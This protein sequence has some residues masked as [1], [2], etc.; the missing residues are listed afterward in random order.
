MSYNIYC[1]VYV[2]VNLSREDSIGVARNKRRRMQ[3]QS[4]ILELKAKYVRILTGSILLSIRSQ[5]IFLWIKL[6]VLDFQQIRRIKYFWEG[7]FV[8][9]FIQ[10][11]IKYKY[12]GYQFV[13][14]SGDDSNV[15]KLFNYSGYRSC[16]LGACNYS[17]LFC[18]WSTSL[19]PFLCFF[20]MW[21]TRIPS[22]LSWCNH[23]EF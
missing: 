19:Y 11:T 6:W 8:E 21:E 22:T 5:I 18:R 23:M 10:G 7:F 9:K 12:A 20:Y 13:C 3:I 15:N 2:L 16:F 14:S 4:V 17:Y 1:R